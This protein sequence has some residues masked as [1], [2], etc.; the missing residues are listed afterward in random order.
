MTD[1]PPCRINNLCCGAVID[2]QKRLFGFWVIRPKSQHNLRLCPPEAVNRLIVISHNKQ[3][4][5][6]RSK[7]PHNLVLNP[8]NI[9][10]LVHQNVSVFLPPSSQN[11]LPLRKQLIAHNQHIIKIQ[12]TLPHQ[13]IHIAL[14]KFFKYFFRTVFGIIMVQV[15]HFSFDCTDLRQ[16]SICKIR[17]I[18]HVYMVPLHQIPDD[19]YPVLLPDN[20]G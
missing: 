10:K 2:S 5:L 18:L 6:R 14:I 4:V 20:I 9:L 7:H 12:K 1:Q 13:S 19:L 15:D 3:I 8:V 16:N 11:I 17:L